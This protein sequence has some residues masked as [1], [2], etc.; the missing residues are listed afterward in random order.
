MKTWFN[1]FLVIFGL[2]ILAMLLGFP[3][4]IASKIGM[5]LGVAMIVLTFFCGFGHAMERG[6]AIFAGMSITFISWAGSMGVNPESWLLSKMPQKI[7]S[8]TPAEA[9]ILGMNATFFVINCV[10]IAFFV[11]MV[12]GFLSWAGSRTREKD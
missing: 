5:A 4:E 3:L 12:L 1:L 7:E 8:A 10:L 6:L 9:T 11:A 2:L